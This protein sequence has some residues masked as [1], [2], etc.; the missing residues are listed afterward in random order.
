MS[1]G[2]IS[3]NAFSQDSSQV[4]VCDSFY[5]GKKVLHIDRNGYYGGEG[6]SLGLINLYKKFKPE[7]E[8]N[9]QLGRNNEWNVDLVPKF[10]MASGQLVKILLKTRVAKYLEWKSVDATYVY[11]VQKG[12]F[13]SKGGATIQKVP[14]N[15]KE[16]LKSDLMGLM[17]KR[18]CKNFFSFVQKFDEKNKATHNGHNVY[19]VSFGELI[20]GFSLEENTIDFIG[21]ALALHSNDSFLNA[22]A[23]DTLKKIQLYM[24]SIGRY[25]ESPFIYPIYGLGGIPEGFSRMCAINQGTFMLNTDVKN[26]LYNEEGKVNGIETESGKAYC[27]MLIC[28]PSYVINDGKTEKVREVGQIIR[29]ICILS[30]PIPNTKNASSVQIIIPQRQVNRKNDIY[31]MLVSNVHQV[32]KKG[33]YVAIVSTNVE[34]SNPVKELDPAFELF[35]HLIVDKFVTVPFL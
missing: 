9:A 13:F 35:G 19:A 15:D 28:D 26:I 31:I 6:A 29:C 1:A 20:K 32:C 25:G 24:D 33:Y 21:H 30:E 10:V 22:P 16:A 27:K 12:G 11:Q 5:I 8:I 4:K 23:I 17:E 7:T 18:R 14:S 3:L 34:T 2:P